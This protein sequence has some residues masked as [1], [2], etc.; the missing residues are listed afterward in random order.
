MI[1]RVV[2]FFIL[3]E[4]KVWYF[5]CFNLGKFTSPSPFPLPLILESDPDPE[6]VLQSVQVPERVARFRLGT[7][8]GS[9]TII[10][11][12]VPDLVPALNRPV[13][14][15]MAVSL[16]TKEFIHLAHLQRLISPILSSSEVFP[17][18]LIKKQ[19]IPFFQRKGFEFTIERRRS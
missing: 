1:A 6:P 17:R 13:Y 2:V 14:I 5:P 9:G 4:H 16:I 3:W 12:T 8:S 18:N 10:G 15:P 11:L 19:L 7:G